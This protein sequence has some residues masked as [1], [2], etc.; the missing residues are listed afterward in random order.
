ML[1]LLCTTFA[2]RPLARPLAVRESRSPSQPSQFARR[3]LLVAAGAGL[4]LGL[5]QAAFAASNV[6]ARRPLQP[7]LVFILRVQ[8]STGQETRLIQ[9]GKYKDLQRLNIKR[10]VGMMLEN[11]DLQG[12]FV[13][14][15]A[16]APP[17]KVTQATEYGNQ[18][19]EALVQILEYFPGARGP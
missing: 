3:E 15:T 4:G 16:Y 7:E 19:V 14:A 11:S 2:L 13:A 5:P 8:E 10:A 18:A 12:R 17:S 1:S 6:K 9:T